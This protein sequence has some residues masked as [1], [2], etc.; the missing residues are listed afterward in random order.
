MFL[1]LTCY[2]PW[3]Y[4]LC[5]GYQDYNTLVWINY[6]HLPMNCL[7]AFQIMYP[8]RT[9]AFQRASASLDLPHHL[10]II[11]TPFTLYQPYP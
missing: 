10:T 9:T 6:R 11:S 2:I 4:F 8:G 7:F 5:L 1:Y 3:S